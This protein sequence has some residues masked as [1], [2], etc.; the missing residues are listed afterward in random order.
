MHVRNDRNA[1][2][3]SQLTKTLCGLIRI[4]CI[5]DIENL[6]LQ[7]RIRAQERLQSIL[8]SEESCYYKSKGLRL[9]I[10]STYA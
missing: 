5:S 8:L 1:Y 9:D 10:R 3:A 2:V 4:E 6:D 7:V